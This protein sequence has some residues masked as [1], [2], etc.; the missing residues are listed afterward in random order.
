M[1]T[2]HRT[3]TSAVAELIAQTAALERQPEQHAAIA[4]G[5]HALAIQLAMELENHMEFEERTVFPALRELPQQDRDAILAA[6]RQ[7][8]S[9]MLGGES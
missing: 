1:H 4:P 2:D 3:Q 9:R 8:R 7:R 6:M 5:L